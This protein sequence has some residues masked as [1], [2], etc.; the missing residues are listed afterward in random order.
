MSVTP[1]PGF[2]GCHWPLDPACLTDQW[3]AL[4]PDVQERAS[5]L[6][7]STLRRLTAYRVGGCPI[8]VRPLLQTNSCFIPSDPYSGYAFGSLTPGMN[9]QGRWVN[10][11][12]PRPCEVYLPSPVGRVDEVKVDG[13]VL[14]PTTY[15]VQNGNLLVW[16]ATGECPWP[17]TQDVS[18]PD[19]EAGTFS[20]TYMNSYPVDSLGAYAAGVLAMEFAKACT[21][22][23]CRLPA[24]VTTI[25]R[26]GITME[27][28]PGAFP[29]G[30]TG[31][32]E[33]DAFIALWNPRAARQATSVWTPD[34]HRTRFNTAGGAL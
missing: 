5:A 26:Q 14:D 6:A 1:L 17:P 3:D 27:V 33:V 29:D 2:G 16:T 28:T 4:A 25:V 10:A 22:T 19:S 9:A 7:S 15:E 24:G 30:Y 23:K 32:R 8:T 34:G 31:I 11:A 13:T 18:R 21:G 12:S 20:V